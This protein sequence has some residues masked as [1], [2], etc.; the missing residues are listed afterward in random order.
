MLTDPIGASRMTV[1]L[2]S[3]VAP[4]FNEENGL[5][6]FH[7]RVALMLDGLLP[8]YDAEIVL[9]DD[10]STDSSPHVLSELRTSDPRVRVLTL[11]R[12]FGHQIAITAGMDHAGG[13]VVVVVDSDLQDPP[14]VIPAMLERWR[15][16]ARVVYGVRRVRPGESGFKRLT[17]KAF[18]RILNRLS[19]TPLPLD[20]GDFRLLDRTVL[21]VLGTLREENR[22]IRGLVTWVG[23]RQE[24]LEYD[25]DTRFSGTTKYPLRKMLR[26]AFDGITSFSERP[27]RLSLQLGAFITA[28]TLILSLGIIVGR[29]VDPGRSLPGYASL[30][31]VVLFLGGIQL[32][33]I[34]LLGEYVGRI[35]R[36]S[37]LRPL[38]VVQPEAGSR[39]PDPRRQPPD[40][41]SPEGLSHLRGIEDRG[42]SSA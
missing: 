23:F 35:Y 2:L 24:A 22:Y 3:V 25:R 17:A 31:V 27:L 11:S 30:M 8:H 16:G 10:G 15:D 1:P 29:L 33:T 7:A 34:G 9:V 6:E 20:A 5:R 14:E 13:D 21:D 40:A 39:R 26:F 36:E 18:Y 12:N 37:K 4:V 32:L 42:R 19:D 38:Y 28:V 41:A